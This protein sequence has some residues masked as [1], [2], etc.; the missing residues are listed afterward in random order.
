MQKGDHNSAGK[1]SGFCVD[2]IGVEFRGK[3]G[4]S[5]EISSD[6]ETPF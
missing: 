3:F 6:V 2:L 4:I 1:T 5:N